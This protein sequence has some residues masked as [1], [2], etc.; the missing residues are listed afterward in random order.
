MRL[1]VMNLTEI[2]QLFAYD[3][4]ANKK[5][6]DAVSVLASEQL[7]KEMGTSF[8]SVHGT[9]MHI[10]GAEWI[11][12]MRC[13][14]VSPKA[15]PD[16]EG[17]G[18][19]ATLRARWSELEDEQDQFLNA[20]SE[21]DLSRVIEYRNTKGEQWAYP[22]APILQHVVNHSTYHRGQVTTLL[23]QLGARAVLTDFL[24]YIDD[25]RNK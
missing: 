16:S 12:L 6:L 5:M 23:R 8:G 22:L 10:F 1:Q 7:G 14:G 21:D 17:L 4:W 9:L 19:L 25:A 15:L 11:W 13:K 2:K 24:A 3:R 20:L 18:D